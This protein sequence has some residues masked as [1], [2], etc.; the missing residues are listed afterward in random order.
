MNENLSR[1]DNCSIGNSTAI[2]TCV[3]NKVGTSQHDI[4]AWD[5]GPPCRRSALTR[6]A[7]NYYLSGDVKR[8]LLSVDED[9]YEYTYYFFP[10][11]TALCIVMLEVMDEFSG[12]RRIVI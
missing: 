3:G 2:P 8:P 7:N 5:V 10:I 1:I 11:F 4:C 12:T 9:G 6:S